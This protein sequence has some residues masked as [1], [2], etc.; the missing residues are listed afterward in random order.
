MQNICLEAKRAA[1]QA[2]ISQ[3][4]VKQLPILL[5][6]IAAQAEHLEFVSQVE[7]LRAITRRQ[8]DRLNTLY[9]SLAQRY[10]AE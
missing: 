5:P 8:L 4:D 3:K 6:S 10:F 9:D 1:G 2:S 7:S